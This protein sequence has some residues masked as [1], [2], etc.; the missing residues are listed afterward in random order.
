M[1]DSDRSDHVF[2]T[3]L[4]GGITEESL[5]E[6]FAQ[7]GSVQWCRVCPGQGKVAGLVQMGSAEEA[8]FLVENMSG[9]VLH[10]D[11]MPEPVT[12]EHSSGRKKNSAGKAGAMTSSGGKGKAISFGKGAPAPARMSPYS[13]PTLPLQ[14]K[15]GCRSGAPA[16][17]LP[18]FDGG[19]KGFGGKPGSILDIKKGL[20]DE[21]LLPGGKWSNDDGA[22]HIGGL[23]PDTT[24]KDLYEIFAPF[25]AIPSRGLKAML[26]QDGTCTGVAFVNYIDA[27]AAQQAMEV[28]D[29]RG[30]IYVKPKRK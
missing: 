21:H 11:L 6:V 9:S 17:S 25:G 1:S 29:G 30:G 15:G 5:K 10:P 19:G 24:D 20:Q 23:P 26:N 27:F 13:L 14:T 16:P 8:I 7:H 22:L 2:V 18:L 28:V 3:G 12:L 4:P